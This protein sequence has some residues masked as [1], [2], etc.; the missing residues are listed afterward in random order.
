MV[1]KKIFI[2]FYLFSFVHTYFFFHIQLLFSVGQVVVHVDHVI[3]FR[4]MTRVA[5]TPVTIHCCLC[6]RINYHNLRIETTR[7]TRPKSHEHE[8]KCIIK[9]Q[10]TETDSHFLLDYDL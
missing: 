3:A 9:T 5:H 1:D 2:I 4:C 7:N 6:F 10:A 8:I